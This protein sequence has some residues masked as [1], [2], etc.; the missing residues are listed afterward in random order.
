M[1][2]ERLGCQVTPGAATEGLVSELQPLCNTDCELASGIDEGAPAALRLPL[3]GSGSIVRGASCCSCGEANEDGVFNEDVVSCQR[4]ARAWRSC[5]STALFGSGL[6]LLAIVG[7]AARS[8]TPAGGQPV[9]RGEANSRLQAKYHFDLFGHNSSRGSVQVSV[10]VEDPMQQYT[11]LFGGDPFKFR[12]PPLHA[13]AYNE[14]VNSC[15]REYLDAGW[16][17]HFPECPASSCESCEKSSDTYEL[18]EHPLLKFASVAWAAS[19]AVGDRARLKKS[20]TLS[21]MED[22]LEDQMDGQDPSGVSHAKIDTNSMVAS[23]SRGKEKF[24]A[25]VCPAVAD[26]DEYLLNDDN[27]NIH[28]RFFKSDAANVAVVVFRGTQV[29]SM[30]N[31]HV[32]ADIR[33]AHVELPLSAGGAKLSKIHKGFYESMRRVLPRVRKW[34]EGDAWN[35]FGDIDNDWTLL[36]AGHSLGGALATLAATMAEAEGWSRRPDGTIVF[37]SPRVADGHL[38]EW[39]EYLHLC[40]KLLRV[41]VYNDVVTWLPSRQVVNMMGRVGDFANCMENIGS[42]LLGHGSAASG[43]KGSAI[44]QFPEVDW[45]PVCPRSAVTVPGAMAGINDEQVDFSPIGGV[46][47]H[48]LGNCLYGYA[49]GMLHGVTAEDKVCGLANAKCHPDKTSS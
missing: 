48:F 11:R 4:F 12:C 38:N 29:G 18:E 37:G 26:W 15:C 16:P 49:H 34:V 17:Y 14:S 2:T 39:W 47:A 23:V 31:W 27:E 28:A 20:G 42:C 43:N 7:R 24:D 1:E 13:N 3:S 8:N 9:E 19:M 45:T 40:H 30:K 22:W 5:R 25:D 33:A 35:P 10:E 32:D 21:K 44:G 46:M 41:D 6:L 36:F